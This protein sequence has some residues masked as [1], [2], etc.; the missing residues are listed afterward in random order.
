MKIT[1]PTTPGCNVTNP[2][3]S[4]LQR[5]SS[6]DNLSHLLQTDNYINE[7]EIKLLIFEIINLLHILLNYI[8][9]A[10]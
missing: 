1:W 10:T 3:S 8:L 2:R 5:V 9:A 6:C 4:L 7:L